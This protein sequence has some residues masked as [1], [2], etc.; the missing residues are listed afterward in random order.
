LIKGVYDAH[1]NLLRIIITGSSRLN[2]Y[3]RGGDSLMGRYFLYRIHPISVGELL[4]TSL[5]LKPFSEPRKIADDQYNALF[6]FGGFPDPFLRQ[7]E[8]FSVQWQDPTST[9]SQ[10]DIND[11]SLSPRIFNFS[12]NF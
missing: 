6:K 7:E 1:K 4:D 8:R 3:R 10:R 9:T 2:A 11:I 5:R 12:P